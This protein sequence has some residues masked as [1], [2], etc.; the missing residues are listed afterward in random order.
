MTMLFERI[1]KY[2]IN[3]WHFHVNVTIQNTKDSIRE[4][5][6]VFLEYV[7]VLFRTEILT[8]QLKKNLTQDVC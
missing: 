6:L 7:H 5:L 4:N 1:L 3:S 2:G 8:L